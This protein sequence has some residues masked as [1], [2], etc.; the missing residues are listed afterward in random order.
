MALETS[1]T[2]YKLAQVSFKDRHSPSLSLS[3]T[4][5][6]CLSSLFFLLFFL[7]LLPH[8]FLR[9]VCSARGGRIGGLSAAAAAFELAK[10]HPFCAAVRWFLEKTRRLALLSIFLF[11]SSSSSACLDSFFIFSS[12]ETPPRKASLLLLSLSWFLHLLSFL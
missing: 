9:R 11:S 2:I 6:L 5:S 1:Y 12:L 8:R 10:K 7:R 3:S 4:S